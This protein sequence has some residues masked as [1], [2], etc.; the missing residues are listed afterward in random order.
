[1]KLSRKKH[2]NLKRSSDQTLRAPLLDLTL[3]PLQKNCEY[4][5]RICLGIW[6]WNMAGICPTGN[7]SGLRYPTK[8][9]SKTPQNIWGKF[10]AKF[11]AKNRK[12][13]GTFFLRFFWPNLMFLD[14][15]RRLDVFFA[16]RRKISWM[17]PTLT[18]TLLLIHA[19]GGLPALSAGAHCLYCQWPSLYLALLSTYPLWPSLE[20]TRLAKAKIDTLISTTNKYATLSIF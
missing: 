9:S 6:H 16:F 8:R 12:I 14:F 1:M 10:G 3:P 17:N 19:R 15:F 18:R 2:E 4:F 5:F 13:R 20:Y 7:F 11:G